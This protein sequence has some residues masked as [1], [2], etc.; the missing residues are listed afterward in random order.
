MPLALTASGGSLLQR[1][2]RIAGAND[3]KVSAWPLWFVI[4]GILCVVCLSKGKA[5]DQATNQT[6]P[7]AELSEARFDELHNTL[8]FENLKVENM[9]LDQFIQKISKEL[10]AMDPQKQGLKFVLTLPPGEAPIPISLDFTNIPGYRANIS[11]ILSPLKARYPIRYKYDG[12]T[13]YIEQL[14]KEEVAFNQKA[15]STRIDVDFNNTDAMTALQSV[16]AAAASKGFPFDLDLVALKAQDQPTIT[17]KASNISIA[18][19]LRSIFYL[20]DLTPTPLEKF[21]GYRVAP[22]S[23]E[24]L[25]KQTLLKVEVREVSFQADDAPGIARF[26]ADHRSAASGS[27]K[28]WGGATLFLGAYP[29]NYH[30]GQEA[31]QKGWISTDFMPLDRTKA[32]TT[33]KFGVQPTVID[34][35]HVQIAGTAEIEAPDGSTLNKISGQWTAPSDT[36]VNL[37]SNGKPMVLES[38]DGSTPKQV[39]F[40][41]AQTSLVDRDENLLVP[42]S[43]KVEEAD[44]AQAPASDSK[45]DAGTSTSDHAAD[46][47]PITL[48]AHAIS[49]SPAPTLAPGPTEV[50]MKAEEDSKTPLMKALESRQYDQAR[51]LLAQGADC[52]A[53]DKMGSVALAFLIDYSGN[54]GRFP[55]D[56]LQTMLA[57]TRDPNPP[58]T[59]GFSTPPASNPLLEVALMG[60]A[61][62][63]GPEL[64]ADHRQVVKLLIAHGARF[65]GAPD[66][67]QA[68]L[69]AAALDDLAALQQLVAKGTSPSA[70][71]GN[72]W[73]PLLVS[74]ALENND[75]TNWLIDHGA[76][77][78]AITRRGADDPLLYA[79]AHGDDAL[80]EKLIAKGAK[81]VL[82]GGYLWRA[83]DLNDQRLFDDL[84]NAGADPKREGWGYGSS[85]GKSWRQISSDSL[86]IC[87]AKGQTAM[88]LTLID[89]GVDPEPKNVWGNQNFAYWAVYHDRP[90]ILQALLDHGANPLLKDDAGETPLSLAQKS[91][92]DLVPMLQAA[93]QK[94]APKSETST[95]PPDAISPPPA[96][97]DASQ[98][99]ETASI[100]DPTNAPDSTSAKTG[101][102]SNA[103]EED[104]F[105]KALE[106][107]HTGVTDS[108]VKSST[109]EA[110][111][112]MLLA[113]QKGDV[114]A[115]KKVLEHAVDPNTF[116]PD[117]FFSCPVYW[118]VHFNQPEILKLLLE[119]L[120]TGD[121][122]PA[123]ETPLQLAQRTHPDL[124]PI[125]EEG[126]KR[127]RTLLTAQL[128]EKL[129]SI[130][131]DLP[132]FSGAPLSQVT[133]FL[134]VD[135]TAKAGYLDRRV[136]IGTMDLPASTTMTSSAAANIS[137]W[138]ALQTIADA[139]K[140]R[141]DVNGSWPGTITLYPPKDEAVIH[142]PT[143]KSE[144]PPPA[145]ANADASTHAPD[146]NAQM[147]EAVKKGDAAL[148][149]KLIDQGVDPGKV[150]E[151]GAPLLFF[152]R[153]PTVAELLLQHGADPNARDKQGD[154]VLPT[155]YRNG[156]T[157]TIAIVRVLLKHGAEVLMVRTFVVPAGYFQA[158]S[159]TAVDVKQA[160]I[161]LGIEF[162]ADTSAI[163]LPAMSEI[164]VINTPV[165]L[166]KIADKIETLDEDALN[167]IWIPG[168]WNNEQTPETDLL[169]HGTK[170]PSAA[171]GKMRL[172]LS[173][174]QSIL[175]KQENA[176][177]NH[178]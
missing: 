1:I 104:A 122:G 64:L 33:F 39:V 25:R 10:A 51:A 175:V 9:P 154:A 82:R 115:L 125:I 150:E 155:L 80:V 50:E 36:L 157:N 90:K 96:A 176:T 41:L 98:P 174:W 13:F 45:T 112:Q 134:L 170:L 158:K 66:D 56:I 156:G 152:V 172:T 22:G 4:L 34:K 77:V 23:I 54:H 165:E 137:I 43:G 169:A 105:Y 84:I 8:R 177:L 173:L 35:T 48:V 109:L 78:S 74:I 87:I 110:D 52:N 117:R 40:V 72:G 178:H 149:Q 106:R 171:F 161:D 107:D 46:S 49:T 126:I 31:G 131:I 14:S 3:R 159:G 38:P 143:G 163:Y 32:K 70:A 139:N 140:L 71:D 11:M 124:V 2:R 12:T 60:A 166:D 86:F 68:L 135:A 138:D 67:I 42:S 37:L 16:Q 30:G 63:N 6:Q 85:G 123:H 95:E 120:A 81:P 24:D 128:M 130:H 102:G 132:A 57:R 129:H 47:S 88:A 61:Y 113:I 73:T 7:A 75:V 20:G 62:S 58:V 53:T 141:F 76:N 17:L 119:H 99:P 94:K 97:T 29:S 121:I 65:A 114:V 164:R 167:G 142:P 19:V 69:Q 55:I 146:L 21:K 59:I 111:A 79:T 15:A 5:S 18:Q 160:L 28:F 44:L 116:D 100:G 108:S 93:A 83:V 147:L 153:D 144:A 91:H 27:Q 148:V 133:N 118:A 26:L 92:P 103:P 151:Q 168:G 127:N 145:P 89:K 136:G 101:A 162:P